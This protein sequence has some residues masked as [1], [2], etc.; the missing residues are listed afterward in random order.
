MTETTWL[1]EILPV[2]TY[3]RLQAEAVL[4]QVT[5]NDLVREAI[6]AYLDDFEEDSDEEVAAGFLEGWHDA[7]TGRTRSAREVLAEMKATQESLEGK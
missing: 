1:Q 2:E 6:E 4:R 5:I 3:E 7:M